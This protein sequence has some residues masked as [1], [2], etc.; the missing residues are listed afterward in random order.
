MTKSFLL[1]ILLFL[2][3][4]T[5]AQNHVIGSVAGKSWMNVSGKEGLLNDTKGRKGFTYGL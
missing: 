5:F 2:T 3:F 1:P 4:S